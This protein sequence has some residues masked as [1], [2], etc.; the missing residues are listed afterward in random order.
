MKS[1][2]GTPARSIRVGAGGHRT[3]EFDYVNWR[4]DDH[5][6]VI[7]VESFEFRPYLD[8][9]QPDPAGTPQWVV[10]GHVITRDGD[11]RPELAGHPGNRRRTFLMSIM[12]NVELKVGRS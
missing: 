1:S 9:H 7:T 4:G 5:R 12:R 10:H 2:V 11:T 8:S 6:Y 3:I